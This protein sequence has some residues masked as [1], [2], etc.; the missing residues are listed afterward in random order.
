ML[1]TLV[2]TD[3]VGVV[4]FSSSATQL[5]GGG[6]VISCGSLSRATSANVQA[7]IKMVSALTEGG[8]TNIEAGMRVGLNLFT[9]NAEM[10]SNCKQ[11]PAADHTNIPVVNSLAIPAVHPAVITGRR[12]LL[13][14]TDGIPTVGE[15]NAP[16]L[17]ALVKGFNAKPNAVLFTFSLGSNAQ[18][19]QLDVIE[20]IACVGNGVA[21]KVIDG[22]NLVSQM[23]HY[24]SYFASINQIDKTPTVGWVS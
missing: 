13:F 22:G 11:I 18:Q 8:S 6:S 23:S 14:L 10:T 7:L 3:F 5:C 20:G 17:V 4:K 24:Y 21:A 16:K 1:K 9:A 12:A 19:T 2:V 15:V